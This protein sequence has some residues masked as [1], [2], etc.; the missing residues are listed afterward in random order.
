MTLDY[1][2]SAAIPLKDTGYVLLFTI[3]DGSTYNLNTYIEWID[4]HGNVTGSPG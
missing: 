1:T 3:Y 2:T 4:N